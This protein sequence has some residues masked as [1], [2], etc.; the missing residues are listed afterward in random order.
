MQPTP[1]DAVGEE[2][3]PVRTC[4]M[5]RLVAG[6]SILVSFRQ[7]NMEAE[8]LRRADIL[9]G[10]HRPVHDGNLHQRRPYRCHNLTEEDRP[11]WDLHI[12]SQLKCKQELMIMVCTVCCQSELLG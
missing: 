10:A 12:M 4:K 5:G 11:G 3:L 8:N 1:G 9:D 7:L 2:G 6:P